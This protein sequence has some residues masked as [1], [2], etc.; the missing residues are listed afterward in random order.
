MSR[1]FD[2]L[3]RDSMKWFT[4]EAD[5]PAG[6]AARAR[7][8]HRRHRRARIGWL[9][10]GTAV[11]S[12]TAIVVAT[13]AAGQVAPARPSIGPVLKAQTTAQV[14]SRIDQALATTQRTRPVE[15]IRETAWGMGVDV[16]IPRPI[17][18]SV[19]TNVSNTW[20][21]GSLD[22]SNIFGPG[23]QVVL[24]AQTRTGPTRTITSTWVSYPHRVW[25]RVSYQQSPQTAPTPSCAVNLGNWTAGQW[26][27][28]MRKLLS[29][30]TVTVQG[31][32]RVDG[33]DAIKLKLPAHQVQVCIDFADQGQGRCGFGAL[34]WSGTVWVNPSTYLPVRVTAVDARKISSGVRIDF[35]WLPP[36]QANLARLRQ[37]IPPGFQHL[38]AKF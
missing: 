30:G 5:V 11:V 16:T 13:A 4:D 8:R 15:N 25:W 32:Q 38:A 21:R 6:L 22:R 12:A 24:S 35:R 28:Q 10:A 37:P 36:T 34:R 1:E 9:A 18:R 3:V 20:S 17:L 31:R 26:A 33:I 23:G 2:E 7:Q 14:I 19:E 29:C 27:R